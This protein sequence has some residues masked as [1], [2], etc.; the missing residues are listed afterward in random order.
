MKVLRLMALIL[1]FVLATPFIVLGLIVG[2]MK[3]GFDVG[4]ELWGSFEDSANE[5]AR[6]YRDKLKS[7]AK[8]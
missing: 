7:G 5:S 6:K 1:S 2:P 4:L 8:Q 3:L